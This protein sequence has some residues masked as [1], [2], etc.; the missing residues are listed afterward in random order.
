MSR[1]KI[2]I[3]GKWSWGKSW[4]ASLRHKALAKCLKVPPS[5]RNLFAVKFW[6]MHAHRVLS[7]DANEPA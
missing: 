1:K 4:V 5:V 6:P 3:R 7:C 2:I